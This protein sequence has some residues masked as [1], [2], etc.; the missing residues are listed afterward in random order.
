MV[1]SVPMKDHSIVIKPKRRG[2]ASAI[3]LLLLLLCVGVAGLGVGLFAP[4]SLSF[5]QEHVLALVHGGVASSEEHTFV[6]ACAQVAG[7]AG[8]HAVTRTVRTTVFRDGTSLSVTFTSRPTP[9]ITQC[10]A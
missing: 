8:P 6:D 1:K 3:L 4:V 10:Q 5:S 9:T 7:F 2:A